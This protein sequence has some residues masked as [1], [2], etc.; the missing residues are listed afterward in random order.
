MFIVIILAYTNM[1]VNNLKNKKI[2]QYQK[3][4]ND[5]YLIQLNCPRWFKCNIS[6]CT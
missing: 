1:C 3:V 4:L 2:T 6:H 5:F